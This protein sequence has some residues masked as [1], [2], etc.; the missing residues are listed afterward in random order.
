MADRGFFRTDCLLT[1]AVLAFVAGLGPGPAQAAGY[2]YAY[3]VDS[4]YVYCAFR[5]RRPKKI[6]YLGY[7]SPPIAK[8]KKKKHSYY[9]RYDALCE[10]DHF[11]GFGD[12]TVV[13]RHG[14]VIRKRRKKKHFK[15]KC[16]KFKFHKVK[17]RKHHRKPYVV[18]RKRMHHGYKR[19]YGAVRMVGRRVGHGAKY[20]SRYRSRTIG[21]RY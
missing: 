7:N 5:E 3:G 14:V 9:R 11:R 12:F 8:I 2:G 21:K 16:P 13:I 17:H 15:K 6:V 10:G 18:Y 1:L 20:A 19:S 4:K